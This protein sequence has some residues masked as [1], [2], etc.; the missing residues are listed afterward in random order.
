MPHVPGA[1]A[2][3]RWRGRRSWASRRRA[4]QGQGHGQLTFFSSSSTFQSKGLVQTLLHV[5]TA[6]SSGCAGTSS[7][8]KLT[9]MALWGRRALLRPIR[10]SPEMGGLL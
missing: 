7:S 4:G 1:D 2:Q 3:T 8:S 10:F 5:W 6:A 9:K